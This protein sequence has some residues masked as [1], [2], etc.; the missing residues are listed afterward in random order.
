MKMIL[1]MLFRPMTRNGL[2]MKNTIFGIM[3]AGSSCKYDM[4]VLVWFECHPN[5][6]RTINK[7]SHR[8][9]FIFELIS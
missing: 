4:F 2:R 7:L 3:S 6:K 8:T 1:T 9:T 5:S